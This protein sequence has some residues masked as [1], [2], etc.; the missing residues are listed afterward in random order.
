[1][2]FSSVFRRIG[3]FATT[4]LIFDTGYRRSLKKAS[5]HSGGVLLDIGCGTKPYKDIFQH[6]KYIGIDVPWSEI[7]T[8]A[9]ATALGEAL[10]FKDTSF[11]TVLILEVLEHVKNPEKVVE[12][13]SRVSKKNCNV[14]VSMPQIFMNHGEPHDYQR[15]TI[16][17]LRALLEKNGF[18]LKEHHKVCGTWG[19]TGLLLT[20]FFSNFYG[21]EKRKNRLRHTA[22]I[23]VW[24]LCFLTQIIF[25][26]M[27][28]INRHAGDP[29][30]NVIVA[31]KK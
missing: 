31:V 3:I 10:P 23:I 27:D 25:A 6:E 1:M 17:G 18:E 16:H 15:Y 19:S 11:D 4:E 22:K 30:C 7:K 2:R 12:E 28:I 24:P 13:I 26:F 14:I 9:D 20:L 21:L 8:N 29:A 5:M